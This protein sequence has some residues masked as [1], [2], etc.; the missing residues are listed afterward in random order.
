MHTKPITN[1]NAEEVQRTQRAAE[2]PL[3]QRVSRRAPAVPV[4]GI[5]LLALE[6]KF[7][8]NMAAA[9]GRVNRRH[10][11]IRDNERRSGRVD[12]NAVTLPEVKSTSDR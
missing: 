4:V 3:D 2:Q 10:A 6:G 5:R 7:A 12:H 1:I 9:V 11:P 8:T